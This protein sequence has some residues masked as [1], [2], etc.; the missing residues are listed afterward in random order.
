MLNNVNLVIN[1]KF[2]LEINIE[3]SKLLINL[4]E[5]DT[6]SPQRTYFS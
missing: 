5:I 2:F 1:K 3:N 4:F 6:T